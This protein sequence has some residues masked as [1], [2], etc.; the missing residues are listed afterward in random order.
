MLWISD[1]NLLCRLLPYAKY[2]VSVAHIIINGRFK[3]KIA[4]I[5]LSDIISP[6][7]S[8]N[9]AVM[10]APTAM[11]AVVFLPAMR[12]VIILPIEAHS[13]VTATEATP[14][15][16]KGSTS[17]DNNSANK[18]EKSGKRQNSE[19]MKVKITPPNPILSFLPPNGFFIKK[20]SEQVFTKTYSETF[21]FI[22]DYA[23]S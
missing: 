2:A 13:T 17:A 7:K 19:M 15:I 16:F 12:D 18:K 8:I 21:D 22:T 20:A 23:F 11:G 3:N 14:S 5:P 6:A 10:T 9:D 4:P 1:Q